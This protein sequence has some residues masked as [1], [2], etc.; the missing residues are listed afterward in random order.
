[1]VVKGSVPLLRRRP[2]VPG[3]EHELLTGAL[4]SFCASLR[5]PT[6]VLQEVH[7]PT[8]VPDAIAVLLRDDEIAVEE[9]RLG[10]SADEL[11]LFQHI[12]SVRRT[13]V[14]DMVVALR[15]GFGDLRR[16][17]AAPRSLVFVVVPS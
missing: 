11:R 12:H 17:V 1:M 7:L 3:P 16:A 14:P 6:V 2:P 13:T 4:T 10:L 8:G 5:A 9:E 15:W